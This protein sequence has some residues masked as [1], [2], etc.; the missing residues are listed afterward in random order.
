MNE[1]INLSYRFPVTF[2]VSRHL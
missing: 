2:I 1:L